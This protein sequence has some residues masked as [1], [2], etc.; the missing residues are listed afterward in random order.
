MGI[1]RQGIAMAASMGP[2]FFSAENLAHLGQGEGGTGVA[3]MGPH[4]FSAENAMS[5]EQKG[6]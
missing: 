2:H 4:F 6:G 5:G 3:S 1:G